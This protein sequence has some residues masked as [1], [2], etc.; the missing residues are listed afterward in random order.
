M[1]YALYVLLGIGLAAACGFRVFVPLLV[2]SIAAL[3]GHLE[4]SGGFEWLGTWP[5]LVVFAVAT[6]LEIAAYYIPWLDNLLDT[7]ATPAAVIAG[8]LV[9]VAVMARLPPAIRWPLA[10]IAG[11]GFAGIIQA[12]TVAIR[13]ASTATTGGAAN[14]IAATVEAGG[15]TGMSVLSLFAPFVA[16]IAAV[17]L[18]AVLLSVF[19]RLRRRRAAV[20]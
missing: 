6:L 8:M 9:A 17:V 16:G 7:I 11:G 5:A 10:I 1:D 14:P 19:L 3:S 18:V 13:G 2:A 20:R 12:A 15:A 4:L